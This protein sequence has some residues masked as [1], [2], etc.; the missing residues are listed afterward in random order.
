VKNYSTRQESAATLRDIANLLEGKDDG[1]LCSMDVSI[2]YRT[3][4]EVAKMIAHEDKKHKAKE[5][6]LKNA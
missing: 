3:P 5:E 2:R 6:E 4:A 1:Q